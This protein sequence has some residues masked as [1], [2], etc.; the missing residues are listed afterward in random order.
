[1]NFY[2]FSDPANAERAATTTTAPKI[3]QWMNVARP[4]SWWASRARRT[5]R[6][7]TVSPTI[8]IIEGCAVF[9]YV[10][11]D[12]VARGPQSFRFPGNGG[13]KWYRNPADPPRG[14]EKFA[15]E[16]I[17]NGVESC[18]WQ[19]RVTYST[20]GMLRSTC[21]CRDLWCI[22]FP[23]RCEDPSEKYSYNES[24]PFFKWREKQ[25]NGIF[26]LNDKNLCVY[27]R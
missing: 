10:V 19:L 8:S 16:H 26:E 15:E 17:E 24:D 12:G 1:M 2:I 18:I 21:L 11:D 13:A 23:E 9:R 27:N 25:E 14:Y 5:R 6:T 20:F 4:S 22:E 3:P 7:L